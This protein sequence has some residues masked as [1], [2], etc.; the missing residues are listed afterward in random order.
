MTFAEKRKGVLYN[1][2][3]RYKTISVCFLGVAKPASVVINTW[4]PGKPPDK[5]QLTG[6]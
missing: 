4:S 3:M 2:K 1:L 6:S 5:A